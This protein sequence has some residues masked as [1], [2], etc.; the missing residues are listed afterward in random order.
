M[1][2]AGAS[3]ARSPRLDIGVVGGSIGGLFA[4]T[5]LTSAGH[6]VQ[7]F[8]RSREGLERRGAGLVAQ[9]ELYDLLRAVGRSDE[10]EVG[11]IATQRI[12]LDRRGQVVHRDPTPQ[13]QLSWDRLYSVLRSLI[14][15]QDY[16]LDRAVAGVKAISGGSRIT[17]VDGREETFDVVVGADGAHSV[18]RDAIAHNHSRNTYAGYVTWRG[19]VPETALTESAAH[20]LLGKFAFYN[21]P[22]DHTLGYLVPGAGG[23]IQPG[24]RRYNWVWYRPIASPELAEIMHR[25]GRQPAATSL[26]PGDLPESLRAGLVEDAARALPSAFADAVAAEDHPFLQAILDYVPP[27]IVAGRTVLL[28]DAAVVVRPHTA[29]G[30][31]KAAGDALL[32]VDLLDRLPVDVALETY[33]QQ[34][35]AVG[36]AIA[37]Y[38]RR[39]AGSLPFQAGTPVSTH[40]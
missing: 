39:L 12:T 4:A 22:R 17:F 6:R 26:A 37:E 29:M 34:R 23:E 9:Q 11:V 18:T 7:V 32:L 1:Q 13:T 20:T 8:E 15:A 38:G 40:R 16:Q 35:L 24:S 36:R 25:S 30:A 14:P 27:R 21:G 2:Q 33:G 3:A 28:G 19:L 10:I 31:A 5:L